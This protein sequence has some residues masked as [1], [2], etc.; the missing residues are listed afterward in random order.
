VGGGEPP[1]TPSAIITFILMIDLI[2]DTTITK[3]QF[4]R[5][6]SVGGEF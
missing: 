5:E 2:V 6:V 4:A 1:T 3:I